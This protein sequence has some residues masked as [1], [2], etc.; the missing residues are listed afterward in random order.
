VLGKESSFGRYGTLKKYKGIYPEYKAIVFSYTRALLIWIKH[1]KG[2]KTVEQLIEA[3][4]LARQCAKSIAFKYRLTNLRAK[5]TGYSEHTVEN[6][7]LDKAIRPLIEKE[8]KLMKERCGITINKTSHKNKIEHTDRDHTPEKPR[9]KDR[10]MELEDILYGKVAK[11]DDITELRVLLTEI[12]NSQKM[13]MESTKE[14]NKTIQELIS[15]S[16]KPP[17]KPGRTSYI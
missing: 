17:E 9:A 7:R 12:L 2:K 5:R 10:V 15:G 1:P 8:P 16:M 3:R 4:K 14:L 11:K 13:S 6:K